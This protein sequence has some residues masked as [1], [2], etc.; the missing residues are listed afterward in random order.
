METDMQAYLTATRSD[1]SECRE[2]FKELK[3]D[4]EDMIKHIDKE[5]GRD[6]TEV[7]MGVT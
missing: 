7:K 1:V 2:I 6:G 4:H 5:L 3:D